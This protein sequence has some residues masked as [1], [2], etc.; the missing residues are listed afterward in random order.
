MSFIQGKTMHGLGAY[1]A[2]QA[3]KHSSQFFWIRA[4]FMVLEKA[5]QK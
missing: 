2:S 5:M 1:I 3:V 4:N